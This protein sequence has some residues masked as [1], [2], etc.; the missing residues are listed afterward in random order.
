MRKTARVQAVHQVEQKGGQAFFGAHA[1]QEQH[2]AV[3]THDFAAHDLV[4]MALHRRNVAREFFNAVKGHEA[5]LGVFERNGV[6][7]VVVAGNAVQA[8]HLAG[9]LKAGDLLVPVF[10][11][12]IGLEKPGANGKQVGEFFAVVK[13]QT[14]FFDLAPQVNHRINL[15]ELVAVQ[16]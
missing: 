12:H 4:H 10:G 8:Q 13:Q 2:D 15:V 9:H 7:G 3:L 5:D 16:P 14:A 1:A 6:A 11:R